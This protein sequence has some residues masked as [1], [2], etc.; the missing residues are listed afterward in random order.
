MS[1]PNP[2]WSHSSNRCSTQEKARDRGRTVS[3]CVHVSCVHVCMCLNSCVYVFCVYVRV[4]EFKEM[5]VCV[6][7]CLCVCVCVHAPNICARWAD[8]PRSWS[9]DRG[10][11]GTALE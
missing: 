5:C 1:I 9:L 11:G 3:V 4:H 2:K 7:V 8:C 6:C 10:P